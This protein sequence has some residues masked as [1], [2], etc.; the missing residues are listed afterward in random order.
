MAELVEVAV[1]V[2]LFLSMAPWRDHRFAVMFAAPIQQLVGIIGLIGKKA[3]G[4]NAVNES[5]GLAAIGRRDM[6][7]DQPDRQSMCIDRQMQFGVQ[8][9]LGACKRL[10]PPFAPAAWGWALIWLASI[11]SHS[12]SG[13]S[14]TCARSFSHTPSSRQR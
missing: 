14:A 11:I 6:S 10:V 12:K 8:T 4:Q 1:I 9:A 2:T 7:D 5:F 13:S 3:V